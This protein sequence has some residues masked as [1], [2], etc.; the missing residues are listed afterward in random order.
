[1]PQHVYTPR[2]ASA[3]KMLQ[4]IFL[5]WLCHFLRAEFLVCC[6][7]RRDKPFLG[8]PL[9]HKKDSSQTV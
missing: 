5:R 2:Q 9:G 7:C 4:M 8:T 3:D 6:A 1:M